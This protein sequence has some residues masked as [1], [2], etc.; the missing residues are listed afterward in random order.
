MMPLRFK[1]ERQLKRQAVRERPRM[2]RPIVYKEV[3]QNL[4]IKMDFSLYQAAKAYA[5]L[6]DMTLTSWIALAIR[7]QITLDERGRE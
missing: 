6:S 5:D 2:G 7:N 3:R 1:K 4:N